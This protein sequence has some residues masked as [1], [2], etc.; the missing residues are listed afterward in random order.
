HAAPWP[1]RLEFVRRTQALPQLRVRHSPA[2]TTSPGDAGR[3]GILR[4]NP[5]LPNHLSSVSSGDSPLASVVT[6]AAKDLEFRKSPGFVR[7]HLRCVLCRASKYPARLPANC[8]ADPDYARETL[9]CEA[10]LVAVRH[11]LRSGLAAG[12]KC[13]RPCPPVPSP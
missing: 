2:W 10:Q 3:A 4:S 7:A 11:L 1:C 9:Q 13:K 12:C 6:S 5:A 8:V